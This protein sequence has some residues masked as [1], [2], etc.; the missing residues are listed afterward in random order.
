MK[1]TGLAILGIVLGYRSFRDWI[2]LW[3]SAIGGM[4]GGYVLAQTVLLVF[5]S[6]VVLVAV[7]RLSYDALSDVF[8]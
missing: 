6:A 8:D 3:L 7:V 1:R 5:V 4:N 2:D